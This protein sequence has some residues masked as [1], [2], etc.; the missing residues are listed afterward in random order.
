MELRKFLS[1]LF[2][3][4]TDIKDERERARRRFDLIRLSFKMRC[5][6]CGAEHSYAAE[7]LM[8]LQITLAADFKPHPLFL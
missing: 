6:E 5:D 7:D 2:G 4:R 3:Q 1:R 8:K